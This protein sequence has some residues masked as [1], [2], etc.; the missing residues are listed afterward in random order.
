M[1]ELEL[2]Q[3]TYSSANLKPA[4]YAQWASWIAS[5]PDNEPFVFRKFDEL[6]A[7]NL[8]YFQSEMIQL[9][10]QIK[11][12]G[13]EDVQQPNIDSITA[14]RQW[15]ALLE[16]CATSELAENANPATVASNTRTRAKAK[17]QLI[18]HLRDKIRQY[19]EA[20]LLQSIIANLQPPSGRVLRATKQMFSQEG[21]TVIDGKAR[22][23]LDADDLVAL[24]S[25]AMDHLSNYLRKAR[26]T[27][28]KP[29]LAQDG[30]PRIKRFEERKITQLLG[31]ITILVA[32]VFLIGPILALYLA[33][34]APA[35]LALVVVFT[36][37]FAASVWL[38]TNARRAEIFFGTA[39]YAAV[40]V[41]FISNGDL[42]GAR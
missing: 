33:Q 21:Y 25:P 34:S 10:I 23:Y 35:R 22:D 12:L 9:E 4:G 39:T 30:R 8:L 20:L 13:L 31:F 41:V 6:G 17:M 1:D 38:I 18:I 15:E 19:H 36:A 16:Q 27:K 7:L 14:A 11:E 37:G 29:G 2:G 40:L 26:A 24:K 42:T 5:D 28:D 32:I 3:R